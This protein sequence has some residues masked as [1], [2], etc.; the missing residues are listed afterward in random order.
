M[1]KILLFVMWCCN[2]VFTV[3]LKPIA[4]SIEI[5]GNKGQTTLPK[6]IGCRVFEMDFQVIWLSERN[7]CV[8]CGVLWFLLLWLCCVSRYPKLKAVCEV[9]GTCYFSTDVNIKML[10]IS[11]HLH[12]TGLSPHMFL[13]YTACCYPFVISY[14]FIIM[15]AW[16]L[17]CFSPLLQEWW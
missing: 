7:C 15:L 1:C 3:F 8:I 13:L 17:V 12:D 10:L 9:S 11:F 5:W 16:L 2:F 4:S 6:G 14:P